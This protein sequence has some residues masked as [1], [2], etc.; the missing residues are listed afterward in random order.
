MSEV[1]SDSKT[2]RATS[3]TLSGRRSGKHLIVSVAPRGS[4]DRA[5]HI[6]LTPEQ[7]ATVRQFI[8]ETIAIRDE[9]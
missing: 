6:E 7:V 8:D 2:L 4:W 9:G 5:G 3:S 1:G